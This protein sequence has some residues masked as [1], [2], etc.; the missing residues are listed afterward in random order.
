[1]PFEELD[2]A[3]SEMGISKELAPPLQIGHCYSGH[4]IILL[5][6]EVEKTGHVFYRYAEK[7]A[8][9]KT[10]A[11]F[12]H[13]LA[14]DELDHIRTLHREIA[15]TFRQED[16]HWE[17]DEAVASYLVSILSPDIFPDRKVLIEKLKSLRNE[18]EVI[19][20]CLERERKAVEFYN[21]LLNMTRCIEGQE[22]IKSILEEEKKHLEKLKN[23]RK[24]IIW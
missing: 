23:L 22:A 19:E 14:E 3:L 24:D 12:F 17:S 6:I 7:L 11:K 13:D 18:P 15:P 8:P 20:L 10:I 4:E 16:S 1:M 2:K 21:K 9:S 5:A